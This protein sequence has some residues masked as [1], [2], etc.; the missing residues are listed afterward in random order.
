LLI[1]K[2]PDNLSE[3]GAILVT[4]LLLLLSHGLSTVYR[5]SVVTRGSWKYLEKYVTGAG[6]Q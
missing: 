1:L 2:V 3:Q 4:Q 5:F 6:A